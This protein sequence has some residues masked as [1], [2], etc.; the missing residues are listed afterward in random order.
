M[1]ALCPLMRMAPGACDDSRGDR[2]CPDPVWQR[3]AIPP[4]PRPL[5]V[6]RSPR[7]WRRRWPEGSPTLPALRR[8]LRRCPPHWRLSTGTRQGATSA[9][10]PMM[11]R[12][13]PVTRPPRCVVLA[14]A[15]SPGKRG[16]T[17]WRPVTGRQSPAHRR[18][19][20]GCPALHGWRHAALRC[21]WSTHNRGSTS[22]AGRRA[23]SMTASGGHGGTPSVYGR[24]PSG[25]PTRWACDAVTYGRGACC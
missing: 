19:S 17:G 16:L 7:A 13:R 5:P 20:M 11:W 15:P 2:P 10:T 12:C 1:G 23:L 6:P 22:R 18:G 24:G 8:R 14:P 3:A 21:G 25:P 4:L 9:R